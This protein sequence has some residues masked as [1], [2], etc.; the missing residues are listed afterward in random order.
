ME[1]IDREWVVG[2]P[3]FVVWAVGRLDHEREPAFHRLYPKRDVRLDLAKADD[4]N[5]CVR[6]SV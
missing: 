2:R 3:M 4:T 5:D 1:P 6:F